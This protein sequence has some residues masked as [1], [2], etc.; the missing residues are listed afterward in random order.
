M[1]KITIKF[2]RTMDFFL[3]KRSAIA[4]VG[5]SNIT[6]T[7]ASI[8]KIK[9]TLVN[10]K[11]FAS[12]KPVVHDVKIPAKEI[13]LVGPIEELRAIDLN[14]F[15]NFANTPYEAAEKIMAKNHLRKTWNIANESKGI[16][17]ETLFVQT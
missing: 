15:R 3:P 14:K 4:P 7:I 1:L 10:V 2:A 16:K 5:Y 9:A 13:K 17:N 11:R 8:E 6:T 12:K